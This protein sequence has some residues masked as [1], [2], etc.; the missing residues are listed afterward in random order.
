MEAQGPALPAS[1]GPRC[2][3][4]QGGMGA[5]S[6]GAREGGATAETLADQRRPP[7]PPSRMLNLAFPHLVA[8][9]GPMRAHTGLRRWKL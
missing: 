9:L 6:T 8:S 2:Q 4:A 1:L 7:P 5:G 3:G